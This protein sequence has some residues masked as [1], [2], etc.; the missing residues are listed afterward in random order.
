VQLYKDEPKL[1]DLLAKAY[2]A[3][4]K[5]AL[6]HMALTESYVLS[7]ASGAAV[8]QLTIARKAP[9]ATFYDMSVIDARE[10]ELEA[11]RRDK[12]KDE[13][14]Q[15]DSFKLEMTTGAATSDPTRNSNGFSSGRDGSATKSE[16]NVDPFFGDPF[17]RNLPASVR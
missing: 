14:K 11:Q 12:L 15:K 3:Q 4:G 16:S 1:Y 13:G 9:D 6:Q 8:D 10:R 7:G 17:Q 5:L 2:S